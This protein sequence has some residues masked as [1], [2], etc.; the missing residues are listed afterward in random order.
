MN[1]AN[2]AAPVPHASKALHIGLWVAQVLLFLA[3]MG[4]GGIKLA[5]PA[6][7]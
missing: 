4:A 5:T 3:F 7:S 2:P 6:E 1:S